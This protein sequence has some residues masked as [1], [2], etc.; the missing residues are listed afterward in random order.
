MD[1]WLFGGSEWRIEMAD[2][3]LDRPCKAAGDGEKWKDKKQPA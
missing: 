2:Y 3:G 1:R